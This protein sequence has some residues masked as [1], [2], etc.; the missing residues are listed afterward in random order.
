MREKTS[1][2]KC[3]DLETFSDGQ[4][5]TTVDEIV[6]FTVAKIAKFQEKDSRASQES[7]TECACKVM[8]LIESGCLRQKPKRN[9]S[10]FNRG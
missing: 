10:V 6:L 4:G 9:R 1:W 8:E 2:G 7:E 5:Q 3:Q